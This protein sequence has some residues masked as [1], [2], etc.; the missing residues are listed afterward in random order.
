MIMEHIEIGIQLSALLK[1]LC[2]SGFLP[3]ED[4]C[5]KNSGEIYLLLV[6]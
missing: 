5:C 4:S 6:G 3:L 1:A 2:L